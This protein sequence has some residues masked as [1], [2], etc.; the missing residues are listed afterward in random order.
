MA[1]V[2]WGE[3]LS[4]EEP[5]VEPETSGREPALSGAVG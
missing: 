4:A 2:T 1:E 3:E 5:Y